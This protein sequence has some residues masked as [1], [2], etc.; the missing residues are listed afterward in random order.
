MYSFS[1]FGN[2][3]WPQKFSSQ[4]EIL[5]YAQRLA[6]VYGLKKYSQFDSKVI[7]LFVCLFVCLFVGEKGCLVLFLKIKYRDN[8]DKII[9][10]PNKRLRNFFQ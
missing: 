4:K 8:R 5:M 9:N 2:A 3:Y 1:Y 7:F 10:S 6:G